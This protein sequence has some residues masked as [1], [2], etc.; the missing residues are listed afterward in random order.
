MKVEGASQKGLY[1]L[2]FQLKFR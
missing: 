1:V 2:A